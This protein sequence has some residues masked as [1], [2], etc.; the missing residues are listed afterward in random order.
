MKPSCEHRPELC[1]GLQENWDLPSK[2]LRPS[3]LCPGFPAELCHSLRQEV[4]LS[5]GPPTWA[6]ISQN[7]EQERPLPS[8]RNQLWDLGAAL[9]VSQSLHFY[10]GYRG[11]TAA[12]VK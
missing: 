3:P 5:P 6:S 8:H 12:L 7:T 1:L 10:T 2:D 9:R 11:T 4:L